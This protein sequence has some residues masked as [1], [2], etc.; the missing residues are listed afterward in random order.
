MAKRFL[1]NE[2]KEAK[3]DDSDGEIGYQRQRAKTLD[4]YDESSSDES[5]TEEKQSLD[6]TSGDADFIDDRPAS[7]LTIYSIDLPDKSNE[8]IRVQTKHL[9]V[10]EYEI[11]LKFELQ[12]KTE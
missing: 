6:W 2:A 3:E 7:A 11:I 1:D 12:Q 8:L 5:V 10:E 9:L 4:D